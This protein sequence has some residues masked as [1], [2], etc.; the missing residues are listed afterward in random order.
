M[1]V[2]RRKALVLEYIASFHLLAPQLAAWV[3]VSPTCS[4][5][6]QQQNTQPKLNLKKWAQMM[7]QIPNSGGS[8]N[9]AIKF[10]SID[11]LNVRNSFVS[12]PG[13]SFITVDFQQC[14]LRVLAHCCGDMPR[15]TFVHHW[16]LNPIQ[17]ILILF[18][19]FK[20][21]VIFT[22]TSRQRFCV[23]THRQLQTMNGRNSRLLCWE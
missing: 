9:S 23:R 16:S 15:R 11:G 13:M 1:Q 8:R 10:A 6:L 2:K 5:F 22:W 3:H 21:I 7:Q 17:V 20:E 4:R 14:E 19:C 18:R 12:A